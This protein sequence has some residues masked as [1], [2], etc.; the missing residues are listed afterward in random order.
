MIIPCQTIIILINKPQIME[1]DIVTIRYKHI[2]NPMDKHI[3]QIMAT[4]NQSNIYIYHKIII[5]MTYISSY[6]G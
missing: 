3:N 4:N 2:I 6:N 5:K 1:M